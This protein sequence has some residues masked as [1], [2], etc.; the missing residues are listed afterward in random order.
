MGGGGCGLRLMKG[1]WVE[2]I[3]HQ[4]LSSFTVSG[5]AVFPG[6]YPAASHLRGL[7]WGPSGLVGD[8]FKTGDGTEGSLEEGTDTDQRR[9]SRKMCRSER[10]KLSTF[11]AKAVR[12]EERDS[13]VSP[14]GKPPPTTA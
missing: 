12:R 11:V 9:V 13:L 5:L 1:S 14:P 7:S 6:P 3:L 4:S 8:K 10:G 2:P